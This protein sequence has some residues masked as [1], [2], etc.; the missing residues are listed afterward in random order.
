MAILKEGMMA[1]ARANVTRFTSELIQRKNA[2][3]NL[4][5]EHNLRTPDVIWEPKHGE[6]YEP[7]TAG[8]KAKFKLVTT[9]TYENGKLVWPPKFTRLSDE[10]VY[11]ATKFLKVTE[12]AANY[13]YDFNE[14]G[15]I[16]EERVP[17]GVSPIVWAHG[18]PFFPVF[19]GYYILCGREHARWVGWLLNKKEHRIMVAC[20][21]WTIG[22]V[23]APGS[24][25]NLP[26]TVDRQMQ[27]HVPKSAKEV[28]KK[29]EKI[30]SARDVV[31]TAH[32]MMSVVPKTPSKGFILAPIYHIDGYHVRCGPTSINGGKGL[33]IGR[34]TLSNHGVKDFDYDA[35]LKKPYVNEEN[36][37]AMHSDDSDEFGEEENSDG[38]E[39]MSGLEEDECDD[40]RDDGSFILASEES[41]G[42]GDIVEEP[43]RKKLKRDV[44]TSGPASSQTEMQPPASEQNGHSTTN[45][46]AARAV[47]NLNALAASIGDEETYPRSECLGDSLAVECYSEATTIINARSATDT[48][49]SPDSVITS[50]AYRDAASQ[51]TPIVPGN[52]IEHI[53]STGD[54][55][56]TLARGAAHDT[57]DLTNSIQNVTHHT[58]HILHQIDTFDEDDGKENQDPFHSARNAH[59]GADPNL[60]PSLREVLQHTDSDVLED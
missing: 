19:K 32:H 18:L 21:M 38:T 48:N 9:V 46:S 42:A 13:P 10:L 49:S 14:R 4:L 37:A 50:S 51:T 30:D 59:A 20:P 25:V 15:D 41:A 6:G 36:P 7:F 3:A 52:V 8:D 11:L 60:D 5:T 27:L 53:S 43:P 2:C 56:I 55:K 39:A 1:C 40:D 34:R 29:W 45:F 35:S 58:E 28:D 22:P 44:A 17:S 24:A 31:S 47:R 26:R 33:E 57:G 54:I 23:I 16:R 12:R